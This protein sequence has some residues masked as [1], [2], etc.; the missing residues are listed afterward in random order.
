MKKIIQVLF[1]VS[2]RIEKRKDSR[3]FFFLAV[4]KRVRV[5][6][7]SMLGFPKVLI[8]FYDFVRKGKMK[9]KKKF[10][11]EGKNRKNYFLRYAAW[12]KAFGRNV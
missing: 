12:W 3:M 4:K 10:K 7:F 1:D 6:N 9:N 2:Y 8:K 5:A 11:E